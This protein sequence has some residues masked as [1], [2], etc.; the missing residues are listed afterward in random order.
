MPR[1]NLSKVNAGLAYI[2]SHRRLLLVVVPVVIIIA[3]ISSFT[4]PSQ[5]TA[6]G[7]VFAARKGPLKISVVE[8]GNIEALEKQ[9]IAS[10]VMGDTK[11]LSIVEEGY[12]VTQE[13]VDNK[14]LLVE[15][16]ATQLRQ[17]QVTE[18]LGFQ[19][20][21]AARTEAKEQYEIQLN[22]N[23]SDI[24][25][26]ELEARFARMDFEKYIGKKCAAE[27]L[28]EMPSKQEQEESLVEVLTEAVIED[29]KDKDAAPQDSPDTKAPSTANR[30]TKRTAKTH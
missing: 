29:A 6:R 30:T 24:T 7:T 13:D 15:L 21:L 16:D 11:I 4:G 25:A 8:G 19:N 17:R 3:A 28:A 23:K 14:K 5:D 1:P 2:R 9:E 12:M 20:A 22:Q 10:E 27:I 26:A 18:E